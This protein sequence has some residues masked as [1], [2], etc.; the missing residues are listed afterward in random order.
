MLL[1][2]SA[3]K[4]KKKHINYKHFIFVKSNKINLCEKWF[5]EFFALFFSDFRALCDVIFLEKK[6]A[7]IKY[8][9][10]HDFMFFG[11]NFDHGVAKT[12]DKEQFC[13]TINYML[14]NFSC[15]L[16]SRRF[17]GTS[18]WAYLLKSDTLVGLCLG[19]RCILLIMYEE[20]T[21]VVL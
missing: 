6:L 7:L 15:I 18:R 13:F 20:N 10:I 3:L 5:H 9:I 11:L 1:T 19:H 4:L 14:A 2:H 8:I 21:R 17:L 16:L 12:L